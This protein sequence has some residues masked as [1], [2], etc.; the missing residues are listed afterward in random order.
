[1]MLE[2]QLRG[3][4]ERN[5]LSLH[6]QPKIGCR[7]NRITGVEALLRWHNP[8]LGQVPPVSFIPVAEDS[9]LIVPIGRWV[10]RT[11]CQQSMEWHRRGLGG[12][13]VAVN[14]SARQF[15]ND[16]VYEDIVDALRDSALPPHLL[17]IELTEG[18]VMFNI[19]RAVELLT[20]VK[21]LG[22]HVAIDDF[23]TG[24]SSLAQLR[25]FPVDKLKVDRSFVRDIQADPGGQ[26]IAEAII[27][28]GKTLSLTVIAEG[29][30]TIEEAD[31]LRGLACDEMQGYHFGRPVTAEAMVGVL[32]EWA[33]CKAA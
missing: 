19:E 33:A 3:A 32:R 27:A 18:M 11:A 17:E 5:E 28:M 25:R 10:L 14:L 8:T 22:V 12:V 1:M 30:E 4:L 13:A 2:S 31:F 29:V 20:A 7:S 15:M 23:G 24:Y 21:S 9:G 6:Y 26:A 16:G